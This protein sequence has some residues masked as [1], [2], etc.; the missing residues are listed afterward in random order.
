ML[1]RS[2]FENITSAYQDGQG[3][4]CAVPARFKIPMI[5]AEGAYYTQDEDFD[6]FTARKDTM[7]NMYPKTVVE[8]FWF[9][10]GAAWRKDDKTLDEAKITEFLTKLKNAYGEYDS[11]L[12][13]ESTLE[14]SSTTNNE[15]VSKLSMGSG[16]FDLAFGRC[17][18]NFGLRESME[19]GRAHV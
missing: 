7:V 19:I 2:Y 3:Q 17:H 13:E 6:A 18:T 14:Y 5:Q 16:D 12:D 8:K 1:F 10:C 11:S 9:T 4:V 15:V